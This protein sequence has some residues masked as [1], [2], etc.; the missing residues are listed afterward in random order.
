MTP[1]E[2]VEQI[3]TAFDKYDDDI[4]SLHETTNEI[5]E[6]ALM[7]LGYEEGVELIRKTMRWYA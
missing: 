4:E 3:K 6:E 2:F 5:M 7:S 1:E